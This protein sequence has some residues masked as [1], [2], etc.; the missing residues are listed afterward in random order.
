M[1]V[2][3][4]LCW[5]FPAGVCDTAGTTVWKS[6]GKKGWF[7]LKPLGCHS[8]ETLMQQAA[9]ACVLGGVL[10]VPGGCG[11]GSDAVMP[12]VVIQ[13]SRPGA[14][15]CSQGLGANPAVLSSPASQKPN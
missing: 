2:L 10:A 11:A 9:E 4:C 5:T 13:L 1:A 14:A 12:V 6:D 8:A 7:Q 15:G 3:R